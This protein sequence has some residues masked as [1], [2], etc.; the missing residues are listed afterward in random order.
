MPIVRRSA[1]KSR[2][3]VVLA[4]NKVGQGAGWDRI[5]SAVANY[6]AE[7]DVARKESLLIEVA[8]AVMGRNEAPPPPPGERK[9]KSGGGR[10]KPK[11]RRGAGSDSE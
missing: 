10:P 6:S 2:P 5:T 4:H 9:R 1:R 8:L 7:T 3:F 11:R